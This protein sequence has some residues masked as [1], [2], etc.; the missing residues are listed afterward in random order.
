MV[1][2]DFFYI[3]SN[4]STKK[5]FFSEVYVFEK[6]LAIFFFPFLNYLVVF[7][8]LDFVGDGGGCHVPGA[9]ELAQRFADVN[10]RSGQAGTVAGRSHHVLCWLKGCRNRA[11]MYRVLSRLHWLWLCLE[12]T[13]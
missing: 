8:S 4:R 7:S 12:T 9:R 6:M 1:A 10:P 2:V 5:L 3:L 13:F 11:Q